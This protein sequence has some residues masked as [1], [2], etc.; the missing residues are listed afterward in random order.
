MVK[1]NHC[2][3]RAAVNFDCKYCENCFCTACIA[4]EVHNCKNMED[5]KLD[6][7]DKLSTK[8]YDEKVVSTKLIKI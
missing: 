6:K 7:R 4:Y 1:C 5:M 2:K 8:L 3:R